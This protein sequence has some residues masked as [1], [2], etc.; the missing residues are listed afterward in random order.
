MPDTLAREN[1]LMAPKKKMQFIAVCGYDSFN[2][3]GFFSVD[4]W[5]DEW[6]ELETIGE[7]KVLE[8]WQRIS[9][10]PPPKILRYEPGALVH[11]RD[12]E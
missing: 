2:T 7:V 10:Y 6:S 11:V 5:I 12:D 3:F 4:F 9:P 8:A 1:S